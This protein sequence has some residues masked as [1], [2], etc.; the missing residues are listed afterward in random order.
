MILDGRAI[1]EE[2]YGELAARRARIGRPV[3][4]GI[5]VGGHDPVI[6]SFVRIKSRAA[7]RLNIEMVRV[8][9]PEGATAERAV[10]AVEEL[11]AI[12]DAVIVQLPLPKGIDVETVLAAI[13]AQKDVDAINPTIP[14]DAHPVYAPVALAVVE[15]LRRGG[16]DPKGKR[17]IV[18]G[19]GRLVGAPSAVLLKRLRAAGSMFPL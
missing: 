9:L 18:V 8:D 14:A 6:E 19:A 13:P 2:V 10:A 5:V 11:S 3:R 4:L 7:G 17:T 15:M 12:T 16:V 1:A